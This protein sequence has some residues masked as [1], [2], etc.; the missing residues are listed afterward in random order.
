[1]KILSKYFPVFGFFLVT[2]LLIGTTIF[3]SPSWGLMD[4]VLLT[5]ASHIWASNNVI[6]SIYYSVN[7]SV[8]Y[9][10]VAVI[11][12]LSIYHIF[13]DLPILC[14]IL[15]ILQNMFGILIWGLVLH[16]VFAGKKKDL[17]LD[18]F[19]FPLVL[20]LF[21]PFWN[22]FNYINLQEK[23]I[24]LFSAIS[25][26][27]AKKYLNEE[28]VKYLLVSLLFTILTVLS[29]PQGVYIVFVYI[30]YSC[31]LVLMRGR[32]RLIIPILLTHICLLV[33][34]ILITFGYK[35][36]GYTFRYNLSLAG[37]TNNFMNAPLVIKLLF[38]T[39]VFMVFYIIYNV[40][41]RHR[42]SFEAIFI[43]LGFICY[44]VVLLPWGIIPYH[45]SATAPY[46]MG[47]FFP[48]YSYFNEKSRLARV[49]VNCLILS[50]VFVTFFYIIKPRISRVADVNKAAIFLKDFSRTRAGHYFFPPPFVETAYSMSVFSGLPIKYLNKGI[51]SDEMLGDNAGNFVIF[52]N[53]DPSIEL[54]GV[55][56]EKEIYRNDNWLI[57]RVKKSENIKKKFSVTFKENLVERLKTY[58]RTRE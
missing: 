20:F 6:E 52:D 42:Y 57:Y 47:I 54:A 19:L 4:A 27:F 43:P 49:A 22:I 53:Q 2:I 38:I 7:H 50:L 3:Y 24:F 31:L 39:S 8:Y 17:L 48:A 12:C 10:P 5:D 16:K 15:I 41:K 44:I 36:T 9:M 32:S 40:K 33:S 45:I 55:D 46:A 28:K 23:F 51:L 35:S 26:Y 37:I 13:R 1:M 11:W 14:Y 29:K 25:F 58:L 18:T 30:A 21:T 34:Y 56:I